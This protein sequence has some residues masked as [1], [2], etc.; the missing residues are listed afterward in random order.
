MSWGDPLDTLHE[1]APEELK[2]YGDGPCNGLVMAPIETAE[3]Y[4]GSG[5]VWCPCCGHAKEVSAAALEF[6]V[7]IEEEFREAGY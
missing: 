3:K 6:A 1:L 5:N 4:Y 2:C 7:V